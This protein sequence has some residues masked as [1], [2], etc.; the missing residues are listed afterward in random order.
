MINTINCYQTW[1][2]IPCVYVLYAYQIVSDSVYLIGRY[3]TK[4]LEASK[5]ECGVTVYVK[6]FEVE[7]FR[8]FRRSPFTYKIFPPNPDYMH[9]IS[10]C[11]CLSMKIFLKILPW[12]LIYERFPP[13]NFLHMQNFIEF[14]CKLRRSPIPRK[15]FYFG[16][17]HTTEQG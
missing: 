10:Y 7:K 9:I 17:K 1:L 14:C 11:N 12:S 5:N 13:R 15:L 6:S 8:Q 16:T 4:Y 3:G 2:Q